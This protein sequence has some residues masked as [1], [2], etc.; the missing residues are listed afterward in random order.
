MRGSSSDDESGEESCN[1]HNYDSYDERQAQRSQSELVIT[2]SL[3]FFSNVSDVLE[4]LTLICCDLTYM[5]AYF[6]CDRIIN[7]H[8]MIY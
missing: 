4:S 2:T 5:C 1:D 8:K 7:C 6:G 3:Q